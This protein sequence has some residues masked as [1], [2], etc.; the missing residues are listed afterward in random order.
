MLKERDAT[1]MLGKGLSDY[2]C[3]VCPEPSGVLRGM[4]GVYHIH[5]IHMQSLFVYI[6]QGQANSSTFV[7][8]VFTLEVNLGSVS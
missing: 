4:L 8:V 2:L 6:L 5:Y 1:I 3:A 7:H